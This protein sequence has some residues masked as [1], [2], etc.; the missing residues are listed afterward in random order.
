MK[1]SKPIAT[2]ATIA[3]FAIVGV[4]GVFMFFNLKSYGIKIAHEYIGMAMVIACVLHIFANL[5]PF[6]KYFTGKKLGFISATIIAAI[7][8]MIFAPNS[9]KSKLPQK[10]L[11]SSFMN[12]NLSSAMAALN[13]DKTAFEKYLNSKNIKFE[14]S[15]IKEFISKNNLNEVEFINTLLN[16]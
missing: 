14:D 15:S 2:T 11:Y 8:F 12:A 5:A 10:E 7:V 16:R 6:K 1:V 9:N 4:T 3:T 13:S